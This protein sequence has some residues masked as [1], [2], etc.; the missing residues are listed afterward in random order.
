MTT[1][2]LTTTGVAA[3]GAAVGREPGGRAVFVRGALPDERVRARVVDE[4]RRFAHAELVEVVQ[5]APGRRPAPCPHVAEGC[6]G[7]GW[8]HAQ[9]SLQ[10]E[11]RRRIVVDALQRLGGVAEPAVALGRELPSEAFR[12]TAR[13]A[14]RGGTAGFRRWHDHEPVAATGCLVLHPLLQELVDDG[15]FGAA[16]QVTLRAGARTGE[17]LALLGPTAAGAVLPPDVV[18]VGMDELRRGRRAWHHEEVAGRRW[19]ISASSF[20]Q[21][22]PD[23]AEALVAEVQDLVDGR[24]AGGGPASRRRATGTLV[25]LCAGVGLFAGTVGL[26]GTTAERHRVVAVERSRSAVADARVNLREVGARIVR[27]SLERWAACPA[28]VVVADPARRGLGAAGVGAVAA[29]GAP[30]VVLVS[31]DPASLGRDAGLLLGAGYELDRVTAVDLFP[32]TPE[33]ETVAAFRR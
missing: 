31:C 3:G 26:A 9:P 4:H 11:L 17:R 27:S 28:D 19:R 1:I 15:C 2:E 18:V 10:R 5:S 22:R 29:T 25:D 6:G 7:C 13:L 12:T 24:G 23:G 20:F 14:V 30:L 8:Q 32:H 33:V 21:T 16:S